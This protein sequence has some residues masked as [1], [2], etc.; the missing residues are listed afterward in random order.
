MLGP[1]MYTPNNQPTRLVDLT[2]CGEYRKVDTVTYV[3]ASLQ[4]VS[5]SVLSDQ[6]LNLGYA[7]GTQE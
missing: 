2:G 7:T 5:Y 4:T 6:T 3:L 1:S